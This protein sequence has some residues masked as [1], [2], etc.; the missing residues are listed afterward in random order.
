MVSHCHKF[1]FISP[2]KCGSVTLNSAFMKYGNVGQIIPEKNGCYNYHD[3]FGILTKHI[4]MQD[5]D[6][7]ISNYFKFGVT[8][9]PWDRYVSK[10]FWNKIDSIDGEFDRDEFF[11]LI[12]KGVFKP[13]MDFF[14]VNDEFVM[15]YI[16]RFEDIQSGYD[17]VCEMLNIPN[18][19]LPITNFTKHDP[20]W[21]YYDDITM[22][23]VEEQAG[24]DIEKFDYRFGD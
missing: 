16:I 18:I 4:K 23:L 11:N 19:K 22:R 21:E 13:T 7:D 12:S 1:I 24:E 8:R 14:K 15:D 17:D 10:Y 9:N 2:P 3:E 5:I 6:I 20:Y